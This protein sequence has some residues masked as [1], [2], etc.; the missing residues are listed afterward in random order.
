MRFFSEWVAKGVLLSLSV[1]TAA[2]LAVVTVGGCGGGDNPLASAKLY[3][4]TGTVLLPDGKPLSSG[5]VVF[6]ATTSTVT[7]TAT[8][9]SDGKFAIKSDSGGGLPEGDYKIRIEA[10]SGSVAK[11][12]SSLPPFDGQFLDEDTSK[13]TATVTSDETKNNFEFKLIPTKSESGA[14]T[15]RGGR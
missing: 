14:G 9:E 6:I 11:S 1:V 7:S 15:R 13:L 10:G 4:V 5:H 3:P 2:V 8:I 12:K